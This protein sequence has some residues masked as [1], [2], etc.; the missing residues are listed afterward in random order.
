MVTILLDK[1]LKNT[2]INTAKNYINN[3]IKNYAEKDI[4]D[5]GRAISKTLSPLRL[6]HCLTIPAYNESDDFIKSLIKKLDNNL[7][8]NTLIIVVINQPDTDNNIIQNQ[9]LWSTLIGLSFKSSNSDLGNEHFITLNHSKSCSSII[10]LDFFS[11]KRKLSNKKGVG[12]ARKI[13]CDLAC[14]FIYQ[15]ILLTNWLHTSDADTQLPNNYFEQTAS[16]SSTGIS[17]AVY[18][19]VHIGEDNLVTRS[20]QLYEKSL[21]YYVE[22]LRI[23][24]S[25]YA[26]H[27]LGSCIAIDTM[28]YILVRGFTKR[29][30]GEDFYCLNKLAKIGDIKQLKGKKLIINA[31]NSDRVP[32]GTGPAVEKILKNSDS[33]ST[34]MTYN[35]STFYLLKKLLVSFDDLFNEKDSPFNW[36]DRQP[37]E[38]K[39]ALQEIHIEILFKH[40]TSQIKDK[41]S[42]LRHI[43]QWFDA[44][45]T[46]KFIHAL[47]Q[48]YPKVNL[49]KAENQ[50]K[51]GFGS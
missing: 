51:A 45:K 29:A 36:L 11:E 17:A 42:C 30:G 31:R 20:T 33:L 34:L 38:I 8:S 2:L 35:P 14:Y 18:D 43:H 3:Y 15:K 47:E 26:Y 22:G 37:K 27:T 13:G 40:I 21:H 1:P 49:E 10:A 5:L 7:W 24:N 16:I 44:F 19:F 12:L 28:S 23:A 41:K 48:Y 46:L 39:N 32:F 4:E 50:L 25:I 6:N 9:A